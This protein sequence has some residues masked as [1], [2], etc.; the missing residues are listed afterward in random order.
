MRKGTKEKLIFYDQLRDLL[1]DLNIGVFTVDSQRRITSFNRAVQL[2]TGYKADEVI[3]KYCYQ[4]F[5]NDLCKGECKFHEA[6]EA[7]QISLSFDVE[8]LDLNKERRLISKLV[9]PLYDSNHHLSGCVEIFQDHSIFEELINRISFDERQL[10]SILDSLEIG[11]F[12]TT[13]GGHI[14]FFNRRAEAITGFDRKDILGKSCSLILDSEAALGKSLLDQSIRD[15]SPRSVKKLVLRTKRSESIPVEANYMALKNDRGA[16]I[17][18]LVTI[19][20]LSLIDRLNREISKRYTYGDMV[21]KSPPM[22]R[23]FEVIS[24]AAPTDTTLLIEGATG[25]GKDLLAKIV[26]NSSKRASGAF[27]KVNCAALPEGL[28]ESEMFGYVKGAFTG[29]DGDKPGRFHEADGGTIFLDEIGDLPLALQGKLLRVLEDRE[30]YPLG[31]RKTTRVDV[32]IV[33]A[34]NQDLESLVAEKKFREDL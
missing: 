1:D 9:M 28:L 8:I 12:T 2:L 4:V 34:T 7:E 30:F 16:V 3:G 11:I 29:A 33:A 22:Q 19:Q 5:N 25:T 23:I 27:V 32:R 15:G 13:R 18:G 10:K 31:S 20:D 17:G 24:V 21:G 26:H 14:S 6:V